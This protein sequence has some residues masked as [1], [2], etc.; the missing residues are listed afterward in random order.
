M[1]QLLGVSM[2][3]GIGFTMSLFIGL[4]AFADDPLLQA[5]VKIGILG[6]SLLSGLVGWAVLRVAPREV[7]APA[8]ARGT[9]EQRL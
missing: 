3:C 9:G 8:S 2:L 5:E 7:P 4:L 6:G 1:P